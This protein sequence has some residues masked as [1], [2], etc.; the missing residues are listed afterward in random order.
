MNYDLAIIGAGW[1]GYRAGIL[2]KEHGLNVALIEKDKIGG[3][4]LNYGCIPTKILV[5]STKLLSQIEKSQ[6]F[7]I[8]VKD[9]N[10]SLRSS[11]SYGTNLKKI[12]ERKEKIIEKLSKGILFEI[13]R[14]GVDLI[15]GKAEIINSNRIKIDSQDIETKY[16]LI[17][18]GSK[19]KQ[20]SS[21]K[22]DHKKILDSNDILELEEIP[23]SLLIVGGG[24]IGCEFAVIFKNLG[25]DVTLL[26]ITDQLLPHEDREIAKK[27]ESIF[28]KKKINLY[29]QKDASELNLDEFE[30]ILVCVGRTPNIGDLGLE[31]IGI[32]IE[33]D[34]VYTDD[35]L[36]T[37]VSSIFAAGDC[38]GGNFQ[39]HV[40]SYEGKLVVENI[41]SYLSQQSLGEG[42]EFLTERNKDMKRINYQGIPNCIFTDPEI[43]TVGLPE[44]KA[45]AL[46][47][48]IKISKF[49]FLAS[50][51]AHIQGETEGFIKIISDINTDLI[52]GAHI[53]GPKATEMIN[54]LSLGIR[55]KVKTSQLRDLIFAHPTLSEAIIDALW[56]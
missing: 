4:C 10:N 1:A 49:D 17:A 41:L 15:E 37:S 3:V 13:K 24:V 50:G 42:Q 53:I 6:D 45:R 38:R 39:A 29:L 25:T 43:G 52:L 21:L 9:L 16:I 7:G 31:K 20:L 26:E 54:L 40:A 35:Y 44:E 34:R 56:R 12:K 18:V 14:K 19:P 22:F 2:A 23:K 55:L 28:K 47:Y 11:V 51:S 8:E 27:L 48:D 36:R 5:H 32:K 33:K 46:G 30:K